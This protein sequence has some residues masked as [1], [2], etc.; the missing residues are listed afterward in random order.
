MDN[1]KD[2][3]ES[4]VLSWVNQFKNWVNDDDVI[5]WLTYNGLTDQAAKSFVAKNKKYI[6]FAKHE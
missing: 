4:F 1:Y 3:F 6:T 2:S 5:N